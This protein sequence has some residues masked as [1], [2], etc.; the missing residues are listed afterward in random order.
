[1]LTAIKLI[2]SA[3]LIYLVNE[4]VVRHS[5]PALGSLIAS[6]PLV[7]LITFVWIW[8]GLKDD[9]PRLAEKLAAHS[10]GV[11]WFVLPS[12]PM[13]LIFPWLLRRGLSFWPNL[14]LCCGVTMALYAGMALVLKRFGISL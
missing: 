3:G 14:L 5:R 4:V 12:L 7:S 2:V 6:L 9:P 8:H 10:A 1:M 13:F 11:F